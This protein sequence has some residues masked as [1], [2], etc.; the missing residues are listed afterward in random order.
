M[1]NLNRVLPVLALVALLSA[2]CGSAATPTPPPKSTPQPTYN[3]TNEQQATYTPYPTNAPQPTYT[4]YPTNTPFAVVTANP[5]ATPIPTPTAVV[6]TA[7]VCADG[8]GVMAR[9][10]ATCQTKGVRGW[11]DG[12]ALTAWPALAGCSRVQATDGAAGFVPSEYLCPNVVVVPTPA[13]ATPTWGPPL[14]TA[15]YVWADGVGVYVRSSPDMAARVRVWPDGTPMT[16]L[17]LSD[18]WYQVRAPDGYVGFVP[19]EYL[20]AVTPVPAP[21]P[22]PA[23]RTPTPA[24]ALGSGCFAGAMAICNDGTC[25]YSQQRAGTCSG[26]GGVRWWQ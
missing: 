9:T 11:S 18:G 26:H 19:A 13:P 14:V 12:T 5:T 20:T 16:A 10:D 8:D 4:P 6:S 21:I 7:L 3:S 22:Q 24:P 1:H 25:S 15:Q 2:G 17:A 23:T